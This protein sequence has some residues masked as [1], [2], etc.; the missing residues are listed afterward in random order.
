MD[1]V[2]T[3]IN[4][5]GFKPIDITNVVNPLNYNKYVTKACERPKVVL[6]FKRNEMNN[7]CFTSVRAIDTVNYFFLNKNNYFISVVNDIMDCSLKTCVNGFLELTE[8]LFECMTC[9]Q[10]YEKV[11]NCDN[12]F[13]NI[14]HTCA[15]KLLKHDKVSDATIYYKFKCPRCEKY[16]GGVRVH[17][18][19]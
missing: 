1:Q 15:I 4:E 19:N 18:Q 17:T 12:C 10:H 11:N 6:Y 13:Y 9:K 3:Y 7:P 8:Q 16:F 5:K 14:C 2:V